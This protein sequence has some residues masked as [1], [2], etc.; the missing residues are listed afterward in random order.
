MSTTSTN[1]VPC[2]ICGG[3]R[4][5]HEGRA[6]AYTTQA[7]DLKVPKDPPAAPQMVRLGGAMTNEAQSMNRLLEVLLLSGKLTHE[8]ALYV[9]TGL[10]S[11][12]IS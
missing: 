5:E 2:A 7:G 9:A 6:H 8:E 12:S 10:K 11:P 3:T 4:Q 1:I